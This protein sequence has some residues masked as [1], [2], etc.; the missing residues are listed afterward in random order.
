M[1]EVIVAPVQHVC[2]P[3]ERPQVL[4][5][6]QGR[7]SGKNGCP[8]IKSNGQKTFTREGQQYIVY[9]ADDGVEHYWPSSYG[10]QKCLA[11]DLSLPP[12]CADAK[13]NPKA[14][15]PE[16]CKSQWCYVDKE[17][18][19]QVGAHAMCSCTM[20]HIHLALRTCG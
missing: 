15:V 14:V 20:C 10:T 12:E 18:C 8:C 17:K 7:S 11:H 4:E 9:K 5:W 1:Y 13:G 19:D 2:A 3:G 16:Y 6:I